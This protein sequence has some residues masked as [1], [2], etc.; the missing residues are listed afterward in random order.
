MLTCLSGGVNQYLNQLTLTGV[1]GYLFVKI[2]KKEIIQRNNVRFNTNVRFQEDELFV[3]QYLAVSKSATSVSEIGCFY[4]V[5]DWGK[6]LT[7]K[8]DSKYIEL[9]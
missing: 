5:P 1:V 7:E 2:F 8:T 6:Y 4:F 3:L 9:I